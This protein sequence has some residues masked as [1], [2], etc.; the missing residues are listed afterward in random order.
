MTFQNRGI[1]IVGNLHVPSGFDDNETY[2]AIVLATPGSSVKEQIGGFY[3]ERLAQR[4]FVA[5]TFDPS[6]QGESGG[7]PRERAHRISIQSDRDGRSP[8]HGSAFRRRVAGENLLEKIKEVGEQRTAEVLGAELRRDP[9]IPD[10]L[11]EAEAAGV[12]D[13]EVLEAVRYSIS[14][15]SCWRSHSRSSSADVVAIRISM[16]PAND[17]SNSHPRPPR[18]PL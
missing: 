9:W 3:A 8:R 13:P 17:C 4:G 1:E 10:S 15:Q 5:L 6:Y 2:A 18:I 11:E 7:E 16:R 14:C 12:R